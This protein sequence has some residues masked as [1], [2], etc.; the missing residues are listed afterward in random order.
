MN[1]SRASTVVLAALGCVALLACMGSSPAGPAPKKEPAAMTP[2]AQ[3]LPPAAFP[4]LPGWLAFTVQPRTARKNAWT[5]EHPNAKLAILDPAGW[6]D[7]DEFTPFRAVSSQGDLKVKYSELSQIPFG[8]DDTPTLMAA[9]QGP[10][11]LQEEAV[12]ILPDGGEGAQSFAP[13]AADAPDGAR[14]WTAGDFA[15]TLKK[16]GART[17]TLSISRAGGSP[18][19][20]PFEKPQMEG[21]DP[22]ALDLGDELQVGLPV[23]VA[24]FRLQEN[25][26]QIL[27][28]RT[29]S[30]EGVRFEVFTVEAGQ[31][32][33]VGARA[34]YLCA[35]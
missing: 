25:M 11:D 6:E 18:L 20:T 2:Q 29:L 27:V 28:M 10:Y 26:P 23:P 3:A 16:T 34:V 17:G 4:P 30:F 21:E 12:W 14:A 13:V 32:V 19:V 31:P 35:Y 22:E 5:P 1:L 7:L 24:A 9:F 15:V 8:C 33:S